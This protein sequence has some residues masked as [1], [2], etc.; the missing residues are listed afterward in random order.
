MPNLLLYHEARRQLEQL[1]ASPVC[2]SRGEH[3]LAYP[4]ELFDEIRR[5][6]EGKSAYDDIIVELFD[7]RR[8]PQPEYAY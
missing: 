3:P 5:E 2:P 4:E 8:A 7:G 1:H 6:Q